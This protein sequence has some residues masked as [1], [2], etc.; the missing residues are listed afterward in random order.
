VLGAKFLTGFIESSSPVLSKETV[1]ETKQKVLSEK[2][3]ENKQNR[4]KR[5]QTKTERRAKELDEK[6]SSTVSVSTLKLDNRGQPIPVEVTFAIGYDDIKK[7]EKETPSEDSA[8]SKGKKAKPVIIKTK[9]VTTRKFWIEVEFPNIQK[10]CVG[11][12]AKIRKS[13]LKEIETK[14]TMSCDGVDGAHTNA[15][16]V[17]DNSKR[18]GFR[19]SLSPEQLLP[20]FCV[21]IPTYLMSLLEELDAFKTLD[22]QTEFKFLMSSEKINIDGTT[23]FGFSSAFDPSWSSEMLFSLVSKIG[24]ICAELSE[25][26]SEEQESDSEDDYEP[27]AAAA[28]AAAK[29]SDDTDSDDEEE[30]SYSS[31]FFR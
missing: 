22:Y 14:K 27:V 18:V 6:Q 17:M 5:L 25:E 4:A 16:K 24:T 11:D 31:K 29:P 2:A 8:P 13:L 10:A 30:T 26:A 23:A 28:A 3:I 19:I 9:T 12:A 1:A 21:G 20:V 15:I 7:V